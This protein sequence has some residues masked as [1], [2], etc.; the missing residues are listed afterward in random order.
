MLTE[1]AASPST[2]MLRVL[3]VELSTS[4]VATVLGTPVP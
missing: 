2:A 4:G 3:L 1:A